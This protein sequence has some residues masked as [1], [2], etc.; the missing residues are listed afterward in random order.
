MPNPDLLVEQMLK[1][2]RVAV[3]QATNNKQVPWESSSLTGDF[4]FAKP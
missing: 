3:L 2:V 1:Q 4:S